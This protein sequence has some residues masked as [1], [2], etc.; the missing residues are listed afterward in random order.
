MT[1]LVIRQGTLADVEAL[2]A[3]YM[4][5]FPENTRSKLGPATCRRYFKK[6]LLHDAYRLVVAVDS[7]KVSGFAVL[8]VDLGRS[9]GKIW[10]L[11]S[12][13][14]GVGFAAREPLEAVRRGMDL[15]RSLAAARIGSVRS[16]LRD[17]QRE[18]AVRRTGWI[19]LVAVSRGS[20]GKGL[21]ERLVM[22]CLE[23]A[24]NERLEALKLTVAS[25]NVKA[26]GLYER[27]GFERTWT[28]RMG[29]SLI[30]TRLLDGEK[31]KERNTANGSS[32]GRGQVIV[33]IG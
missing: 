18:K 21:G 13:H 22:E 7:G 6:V 31:V 16:P 32:M 30:Y 1:N 5:S 2:A 8:H 27:M 14:E 11:R 28:I 33:K 20:R 15:L 23:T 26:I 29:E 9:L 17:S 12:W 3:L 19:E 25:G 4:E 24:G 10:M